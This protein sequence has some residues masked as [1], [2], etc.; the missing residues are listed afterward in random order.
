MAYWRVLVGRS[1][2]VFL[3]GESDSAIS[4][5]IILHEFLMRIIA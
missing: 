3:N 5:Q 4:V 2:P 1:E